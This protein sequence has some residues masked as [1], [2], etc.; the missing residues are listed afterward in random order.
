MQLVKIRHWHQ[1]SNAVTYQKEAKI[2]LKSFARKAQQRQ[3]ST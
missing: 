3:E 1:T 2:H